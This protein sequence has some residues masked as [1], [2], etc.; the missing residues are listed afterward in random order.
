MLNKRITVSDI[1]TRKGDD[2]LVCLTAYS[3]P[4][5]K[6]LDPHCD[7]LLVGDSLGMVLY[8]MDNTL[9]VTLDMMINHGQAVMRGGGHSCVVVDMPFGTYE[10]NPETA[11]ENALRV[12]T[13]TGCDAVKLEG[14]QDMAATTRYLSDRNIPVMGHIGLQPQSILKDGGYKVKGKTNEDVSRLIEDAKA[15]ESAGAFSVVIEGTIEEVAKNIT[16]S[17][18]IPTIGIGASASCDGQVL[19][20]EDM[21]GLMTDHKP[22]FVKHYAQLAGEI[23]QA[24]QTYASDVKSRAFPS[25]DYTYHKKSG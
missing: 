17:I 6:I 20:A 7:V 13:E 24:A 12:I 2:P 18:D 21:L 14:G 1:K 5:A 19:V 9:G 25:E 4:M 16:H 3:T 22:K 8:G 11:Y 10:Q 23:E 15:V